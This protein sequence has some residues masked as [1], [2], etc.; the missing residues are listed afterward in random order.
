MS[1]Y[2]QND[3]QL[4]HNLKMIDVHQKSTSFRFYTDRGVFSKDRL[5][6][7]TKVLVDAINLEENVKHIVDM[8]CGYGAIGIMM[9]TWYPNAIVSMIDVNERAVELS[10]KNAI[11]NGVSN[12]NIQTSFLFEAF[13]KNV[14]VII[15]NPPIRAGKQ[16][17]FRLY[18]QAHRHL[19]ENGVFYVVIQK[20]QGAP[21]TMEKL[22]SLFNKV[23]VI[24]K[25]KGY[26]VIISYK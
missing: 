15:T 22:Q 6:Y 25:D 26:W 10:Q 18:E 5:D 19:N 8:G 16:T 20:K 7:G 13:E 2:Y 4:D 9:A 17:V 12:V 23:E 14:D 3:P 1:H 21:S 11:L 24:S